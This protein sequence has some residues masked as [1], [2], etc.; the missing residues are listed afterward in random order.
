M[1]RILLAIVL[2]LVGTQLFA[3]AHEFILY[4]FPPASP[5]NWSTPLKL[6]YG[7]GLKGRMVFEHGKNKHTIGHC[8]MEL[9]SPDGDRELTGST[10]APDAPSD[11][12]FVTKLGYGLGV[13]FAPMKGALDSSEKLDE[14]LLQRYDTGKVIFLRFIIN[15][16]AYGE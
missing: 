3:Q 15:E 7:A 16:E 5:L 1:K 9:K 4:S 12:D 13:L 6:A 11:A 2:L 10:T 8:F 14:E